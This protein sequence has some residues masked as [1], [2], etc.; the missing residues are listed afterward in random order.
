MKLLAPSD[1]RLARRVAAGDARA[2]EELWSSS[3][4]RLYRFALARV[5]G[6]PEAA[7]E[8][9]QETMVRALDGLAEFQGRS[10]LH[11]WLCGIC[12]HLIADRRR[13]PGLAA[14]IELAED[15]PAVRA[16]LEALSDASA[17][18][19]DAVLRRNELVRLVH[20]TLDALPASYGRALAL[21]YLDELP[22]PEVARRL[23]LPYKAAESVLSRARQAFRN[24]IESVL[25][26]SDSGGGGRTV[27]E[28]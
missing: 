3:F 27:S 16:A 4:Q 20:A 21:R 15:V 2:F 17:A 22:V 18:G 25:E 9:A 5:D 1:R 11:T 13:R 6:D 14:G 24:G 23:G 12:R 28:P 8:L 7:A 26:A 19:P 10:S